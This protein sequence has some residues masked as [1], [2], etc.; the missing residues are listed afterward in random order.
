MGATNSVFHIVDNLFNR[1]HLSTSC[2]FPK[3]RRVTHAVSRGRGKSTFKSSFTLPGRCVSTSTRSARNRASEIEC[4]TISTVFCLACQMRENPVHM[5]SRV[6][7]SRE[8]KGSSSRSRSGS[9]M[10]A[11][12]I[13]TR[14]AIPPDKSDGYALENPG[15][16]SRLTRSLFRR[17]CDAST[18]LC[19]PDTSNGNSAFTRRRAPGHQVG[20]LKDYADARAARHRWNVAALTGCGRRP[21][22]PGCAGWCSCRCPKAAQHQRPLLRT[23]PRSVTPSRGCAEPPLLMRE[24]RRSVRGR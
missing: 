19:T 14:W 20:L 2:Q 9:W 24:T 13:A 6:R 22:R 15:G 21:A 8:P 12:A 10:S 1:S 5:R 11:R 3:L 4:V 17:V 7:A 23:R 16:T 18:L